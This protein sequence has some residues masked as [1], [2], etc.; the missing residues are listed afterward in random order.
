LQHRPSALTYAV[1]LAL[2][3]AGYVL[4]PAW[5]ILAGAACLTLAG[6]RPWRLGPHSHIA[7]TS[8]TTT[9]FVTGILA[10]LALAALSYGAGRIV[11]VLLG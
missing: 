11:R 4:A 8:K 7:W 3:A 2:A 6:W 5:T 10:D 9:Y 1:M